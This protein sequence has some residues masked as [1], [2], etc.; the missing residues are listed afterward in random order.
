[1]N[2][3]RTRTVVFALAAVVVASTAAG[4]VV[5]TGEPPITPDGAAVVEI[6]TPGGDTLS[7]HGNDS[8]PPPPPDGSGRRTVREESW[9]CVGTGSDGPRVQLLYVHANGTPGQLGTLRPT[10]ES[11]AR[12]IEGAFVVSSLEN[13]G[14]ERRLRL[15]TDSACNLTIDDVMVS[16]AALASFSTFI[17]ELA[18]KGFNRT[19]RKYHAWVES[20]AYCGIGTWNEDDQPGQTNRSNRGPSYARSDRNCWNYAEA[21]EIL[22]N[23]GAVQDS[24]ANSTLGAHC[25]DERDVMCYADGAPKGQMRTVCGDAAAEDLFDCRDDDYFSTT[26]APNPYFSSHWN[27][28]S[29]AWL[30]GPS[31]TVPP[32][33]TVVPPT[34][35]P[36]PTTSTTVGKGQTSVDLTLSPKPLVVNRQFTATAKVRGDC[37]P[38]G[39]VSFYFSGRLLLRQ[40]VTSQAATIRITVTTPGR[41]TFRA[42]YDGSAA[43]A[44]SSESN[45][46]TVRSL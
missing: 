46:E 38:T 9:P 17:N 27:V 3:R 16:E 12:R 44:K 29:S 28:A 42:T 20:N 39:T 5:N 40:T 30:V 37:G 19:D 4:V 32:P 34:T 31:A 33:T 15:V 10:L 6:A 8:L 36:P 41:F 7:T 22:H 1:M 26:P 25:N 23:L 13:G 18:A 14:T 21:H 11:Y 35:T 2:R 24:A 45:R 43:C